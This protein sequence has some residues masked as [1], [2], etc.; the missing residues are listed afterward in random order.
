MSPTP[1][2]PSGSTIR[3]ICCWCS[4]YRCWDPSLWNS[5]GVRPGSVACRKMSIPI[6]R[7]NPKRVRGTMRVCVTPCCNLTYVFRQVGSLFCLDGMIASY[8]VGFIDHL[9][10]KCSCGCHITIRMDVTSLWMARCRIITD[11]CVLLPKSCCIFWLL[12]YAKVS[13]RNISSKVMTFAW[14]RKKS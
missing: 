10:V 7:G 8:K 2:S 1:N 13:L 14:I 6:Q 9:S 4:N 12:P 5:L 3:N 11:L